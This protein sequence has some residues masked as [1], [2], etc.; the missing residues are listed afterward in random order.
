MLGKLT[1][2]YTMVI[3]QCVLL[4]ININWIRLLEA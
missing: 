3:V 1:Y 4:D 2:D